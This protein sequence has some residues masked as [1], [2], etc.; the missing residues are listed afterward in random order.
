VEQFDLKEIL[1]VIADEDAAGFV[2]CY[3]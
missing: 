1:I 3:E 2:L